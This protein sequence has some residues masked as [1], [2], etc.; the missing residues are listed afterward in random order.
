MR[1]QRGFDRVNLHRPTLVTPYSAPVSAYPSRAQILSACA[2]SGPHSSSISFFIRSRGVGSHPQPQIAV[3]VRC[4][5][6][7]GVSLLGE[8]LN[9]VVDDAKESGDRA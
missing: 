8:W 3:L 1:F 7:V 6:C 9:C 5:T 2:S 4:P